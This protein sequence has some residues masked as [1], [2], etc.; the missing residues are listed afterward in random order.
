MTLHVHLLPV[1]AD[2][3]ELAGH[4]VV[5]IDVLRASTTIVHALAAGASDVV[6]CLEIRDARELAAKRQGSVVLGGERQGRPI[7][8][9]DLGNSPSQYTADTVAGKSVIF[10]TTNGTGALI[11]C[12]GAGRV[13]VAGFVNLA[14]VCRALGAEPRVEI[15]CAGTAGQ[16]SREDVLLAGAIVHLLDATGGAAGPQLNDQAAIA[17]DAWLAAIESAPLPQLLRESRGGRNLLKLG[18]DGDIELAA[19]RDKFDLVPELDHSQWCLR[20]P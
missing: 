19:S 8:G 16:V 13:L 15:V 14:A 7:E 1:L 6:P 20:L 3:H 9:F 11:A 10:T 18:Y 17:R 5:L 12:Q 2:P 4:T